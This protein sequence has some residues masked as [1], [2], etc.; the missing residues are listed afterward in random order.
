[1]YEQVVQPMAFSGEKV[2]VFLVDAFRYEMATELV[3]DLRATGG[4]AVVDLKARFAELPTITSVGM[5]ALAPVAQEGR[6]AVAGTF[7]GFRTGE[8]TVRTPTDRARAMGTRTS[9][10]PGLQLT[11]AEVCDS[12]PEGLKRK[13]KEHQIVVVCSSEI[14]DAGEAN[15]GLLTFEAQLRQ[16]K[17]AWHHLQSAGIKHAVLTA[18]HGFLLQDSTTQVRPFG[19]KTD[20]QRRYIL[21]DHERGESGIVPV[22]LSRLGYD[23]ISGYVLVAEDTAVFATGTVGA[24]FV[25]GGN[26]P[27]ER[28]I[29]VLT[30][31]RKRVEASSLAEYAVEA[32]PMQ[33]AF[34]FHRM[35]VRLIFPRD[36]QTS[37]GFV[38]ARAIDLDLRVPDRNDIRVTVKEVSGAGGIKSGRIHAPVGDDWS[39]V[40]FALEGPADERV[41]VEV[42]HG[43]NIENV[44]SCVPD[45]LFGVSG[46][47]GGRRPT[48]VPPPAS[49]WADTIEDESIR[50]VFV[51]I[52]KHGSVTEAEIITM[53]GNAR[54]ARRF[55]LNFDMYIEKLPFKVRS[56]SN[57]SGKR[58]VREE[59]K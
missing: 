22:A 29:P 41:R 58:Y 21:D 9:G 16:I 23:G 52:D 36:S 28:I 27:E 10:K 39:E 11:L 5:N 45:A 24:S 59:E 51:H 50:G 20:P 2:A 49:S 3:E 35:R 13:V 37:L 7:Q 54:A 55:A 43:D 6:L 47:A 12:S 40:F 38:G 26:S 14:D 17:A 48:T 46:V 8:Y 25:H 56:E 33:D 18:D 42:H 30:V 31:T 15:V 34:G 1:L 19:K 4:G 53:L 44:R 32:E 57:V